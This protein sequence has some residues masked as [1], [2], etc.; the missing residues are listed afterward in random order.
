MNGY[1]NNKDN[2]VEVAPKTP[3]DTENINASSNDEKNYYEVT[4]DTPTNG[5]KNEIIDNNEEKITKIKMR[6]KQKLKT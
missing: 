5:G 6:T 4:P 2:I 1:S 3:T